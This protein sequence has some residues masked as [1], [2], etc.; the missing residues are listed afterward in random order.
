M[1]WK[2]LSW[3]GYTRDEM[4]KFPQS[5]QTIDWRPNYTFKDTLTIVDYYKGRSAIHITVKDSN[6]VKYNMFLSA[7]WWVVTNLT[8]KNGKVDGEWTFVKRGANYGLG[9]I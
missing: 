8:I 9:H 7:F 1:V 6:G 5:A 2:M 3:V 4:L